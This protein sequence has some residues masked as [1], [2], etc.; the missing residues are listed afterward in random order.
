MTKK[1]EDYELLY[2]ELL[3]DYQKKEEEITSLKRRIGGYATQSAKM[4]DKLAGLEADYEA[5]KKSVNS[6]TQVSLENKAM[7]KECIKREQEMEENY[8]EQMRELDHQIIKLTEDI[9]E[10]KKLTNEAERERLFYKE[11][12]EFFIKL[13]WYKRLFV[14]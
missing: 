12:Y 5:A 14:K 6:L 9:C 11:N 3:K 10:Q 13:P 4:K 8:K 1:K 7:V 2:Y